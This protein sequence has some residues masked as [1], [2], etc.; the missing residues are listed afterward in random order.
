MSHGNM[1][2]SDNYFICTN[3][4][5]NFYGIARMNIKAKDAK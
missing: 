1:I 5:C 4:K 3:R 2:F